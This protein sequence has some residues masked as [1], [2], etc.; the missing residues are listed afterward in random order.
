MK[1]YIHSAYSANPENELC[2]SVNILI[3]VSEITKIEYLVFGDEEG[4]WGHTH[5]PKIYLLTDE[6]A[7]RLMDMELQTVAD[8][9]LKLDEIIL[10]MPANEL[11]ASYGKI[12]EREREYQNI[13]DSGERTKTPR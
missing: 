8:A 5:T 1:K 11:A 7:E 6:D 3:S 12:L 13:L 4:W 2:E 10:S 9:V